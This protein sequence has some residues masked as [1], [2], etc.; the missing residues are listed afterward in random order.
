MAE[1]VIGIT[2]GIGSG[3]SMVARIC[4]IYGY[5][6]YDCDKEA[7]RIMQDSPIIKSALLQRFGDNVL[8]TDLTINRPFLAEKIFND[9][10]HRSWLNTI[11]HN[12]VTEDIRR[13]QTEQSSKL[14][15]IES[16]ILHTSGLDRIVD[17]IWL[18]D[19]DEQTRI[20]RVMQRNNMQKEEVIRRI[21][22]QKKE[23]ESLKSLNPITTITNNHNDS[24]LQQINLL[25]NQMS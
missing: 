20:E 22:T 21:Q 19:A 13:W 17:Y 11:V 5:P 2:G 25:L 3:K 15:F 9:D 6:V 14:I 4:R 16:A 1:S 10:E 12:A 7:K 24:L 23:F 18:V 8:N